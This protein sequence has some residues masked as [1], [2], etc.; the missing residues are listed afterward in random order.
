MFKSMFDDTRSDTQSL[1]G[2]LNYSGTHILLCKKEKKTL[3][4]QI[5]SVS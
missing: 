2:V 4:L 3:D 1:S 5:F